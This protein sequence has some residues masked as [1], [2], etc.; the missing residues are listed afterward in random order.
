MKD[1]IIPV[2]KKEMLLVLSFAAAVISCLFVPVTNYSEYIDTNTIG[3]IFSLMATVSGI[4]KTGL[5]SAAA[6]MLLRITH[7][8]RPLMLMLTLMTFFFSMFMTNS[9]AILTFVPFT[10]TLFSGLPSSCVIYAVAVQTIAANLGSMLTPIGNPQN[11]Y[12]YNYYCLAPRQ[13][14]SYI[15][16]LGAASL[17]IVVVLCLFIKDREIG[18]D[19]SVRAKITNPS[20]LWVYGLLFMLALFSVFKIVDM[21]TVFA[22]VCVVLV[23]M[24]PGTFR[25]IDYSLLLTFVFFFIFAGNIRHI[26]VVSDFI[27]S[28]ISG[29]EF[30]ATLLLSQLIS[31]LPAS[32]VASAFTENSRAVVLG[33]NIAGVGAPI[34]SLASVISMRLYSATSKSEP[35]KYIVVFLL[36]DLLVMAVLIGTTFFTGALSPAD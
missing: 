32:A 21:L 11:L 18:F 17:C 12:L 8:T 35:N 3:L 33:A 24:E 25:N 34:A 30:T 29:R 27:K 5:F 7:R 36:L 2:L 31:S 26:V 13:F 15:M 9:G 14:F 6:G 28:I 10:L 4:T 22:S 23:I 20:Y 19:A 16:P 1:K